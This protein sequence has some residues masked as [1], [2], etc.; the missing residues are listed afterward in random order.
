MAGLVVRNYSHE[1]DV[2]VRNMKPK[3]RGSFLKHCKERGEW[4]ELCF[5]AR[6]AELGLRVSKPY[7]DSAGYDVGVERKGKVLR[8]QVKSTIYKRRGECYSLNVMGPKRKRYPRGVLDFFAVYLI[9]I[10]RWYIIPYEVMGETNCSLHFTPGSK[11]EKY[12]AYCEAWQLLMGEK[13][14]TRAAAAG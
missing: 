5:M 11:R 8:V 6:A 9:P 4:A 3:I 7:G 13:K 14:K 10:D 2:E 1:F 12:R